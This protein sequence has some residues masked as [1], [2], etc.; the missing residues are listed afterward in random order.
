MRLREF[1]LVQDHRRTLRG[2]QTL[3][4]GM[5]NGD[6]GEQVAADIEEL[7]EEFGTRFLAEL[8]IPSSKQE[9]VDGLLREFALRVRNGK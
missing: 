1:F 3:Q 9:D 2:L 6:P 7:V 4:E 5:S 8:H